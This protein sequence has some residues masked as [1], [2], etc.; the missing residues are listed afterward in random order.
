[1]EL[2]PVKK[3]EYG[4]SEDFVYEV[5]K[6]TTYSNGLAEKALVREIREKPYYI[7]PLDVVVEDEGVIIGTLSFQNFQLVIGMKMK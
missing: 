7:P 1:M 4:F 5:F 2:R 6:N 3:E